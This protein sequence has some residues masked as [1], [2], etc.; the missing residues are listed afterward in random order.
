[1]LDLGSVWRASARMISL[2]TVPAVSPLAPREESDERTRLLALAQFAVAELTTF[3]RLPPLKPAEECSLLEL[4]CC[5]SI[6]LAWPFVRFLNVHGGVYTTWA[7]LGAEG[8]MRTL[9]LAA[10]FDV[11]GDGSLSDAESA[12][13]TLEPPR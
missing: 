13:G 3:A 11:D 2:K 10:H 4:L 8:R 9:L 1:M 7:R 12:L 5:I 6:F